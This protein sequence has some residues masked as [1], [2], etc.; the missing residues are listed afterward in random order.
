MI[1]K[2]SCII[3]LF[4]L[5]VLPAF[6]QETVLNATLLRADKLFINRRY[7]DAVQVYLKYLEKYPKDYYAERQTA[8]CYNKLNKPDDAIDHWPLVVESSE[9]TEKDYLEYGKSL[10]TNNRIPEAKKIFTVLSRS[11][12]KSLAAWG[13]MY[14]NP[15][16]LYIDSASVKVVEVIGLNTELPQS[17]PI[18]F[19]DKMYYT[20]DMVR[21][22]RMF[23]TLNDEETQR[24]GGALK[25][26]SLQLFPSILNEKLHTVPVNGSFCFSPDGATLYFTRAVSSRE[27][28]AKGSETYFKYQIYTL[29]MSTLNNE[30]PEIKPFRYNTPDHDLMHPSISADGKHLLF[31]SDMKGSAGGKDIFIC[32]WTSNGWGAPI[33]AGPQVNSA[34][35][36]VFPAFTEDNTLYFSSDYKPGLGGLDIFFAPLSTTKD[37]MFEEAENVGAP[38]NSRYDD[39]GI[40][41]LKGGHKGYLSSNRKNNTDDDIYYFFKKK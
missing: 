10:L 30:V 8:L 11:K 17:C 22:P 31:A 25:K 18:I 6:S 33:N 21:S 19:K 34:G 29:T 38:M 14:L 9:A 4:I 35:N 23:F 7:E 20:S 37:K 2:I 3:C 16:E 36:E 39:F 27:L 26:D 40:F 24:I 15:A 1:R 28:K 41:I 12:D 32:E 5:S 13:K